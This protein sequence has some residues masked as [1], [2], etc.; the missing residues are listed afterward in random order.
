MSLRVALSATNRDGRCP[1]EE[2]LTFST[3]G[4]ETVHKV[5]LCKEYEDK[6]IGFMC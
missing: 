6:Q 2:A 3:G 5:G 1:S 4:K